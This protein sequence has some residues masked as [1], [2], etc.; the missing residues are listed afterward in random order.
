MVRWIRRLLFHQAVEEQLDAELRFHLDQQSEEYVARGMSPEEAH[1]RA[2][3]DMAGVEQ[4][5]QRCRERRWENRLEGVVRDI[6]FAMRRL[7]KEA[8]FSVMAILA[9]SLG[10]GSATL[11]FSLVYNLLFQPFP[12]RSF[13]RSTVV[14][15]HDMSETG[16][17]GR[18]LFSIPEFL[19]FRERNHA[20]EDVVGYNNAVNISYNDG[21]GTREIFGSHGV[22]SHAGSG[23]AYVTTNTF[24][25]YG[26]VPLSGRGIKQEDGNPGAQPVFVMNYRLWQEMFHGDPS[27]LG[28]SFLLNGEARTLVGIMPPRFQIY[29]AGVWLPIVLD[30]GSSQIPEGLNI[31]GSLKPG[32]S[33][34]AAAAD[35][36][37]IARGLAKVYPGKYPVRFTVITETLVESLLRRFKTTLYAL[38]VAVSML[39]LIACTNVASLL[40]VRA[41]TRQGEV[42]L[43][44]SLGAS[45]TRLTQQFLVEALVLASAGCILGCIL[46]YASLKWLVALIPAHRIP[47]GVVFHLNLPVLFFAVAISMVTTLVCGFVPALHVVGRTLQAPLTGSGRGSSGGG[48]G[49]R[50]TGLVIAQIAIS[51]VLLTAAGL[52]MRS[53]FA[54]DHVDL[55]FRPYSVLYAR[56][57]LPKGRYETAEPRRILLRKIVDRVRTLPGVIAAAETWSLPPDDRKWS[58][59]TIP[60][61]THSQEWDANTNLCSQD[62]FQTLDLR[63]LRGRLLSE[64]DVESARHVV[65]INQTL[66]HRFFGNDDPIGHSIKFNQFDNL[67][68]TPHDAYFEIIGIV[69][70]YRNAGLKRQPVPEAL[71]PYTI[72]PRGV[73]NILARTALKPN[74]LLKSVYQSVWAVDPE[75]GIGMSGSLGNLLDEYEY[76]EPL[77]EVAV[78]GAFAGMGLL[79]VIVGVYSVMAYTVALRTHE[80]GVRAALG[81]Q[82][83]V[84]VWMVLKRALGMIMAGI[85]IG[86]FGSLGVTHLLA[87][88]LWGVSVTDPWTFASVVVCVLVVGLAACSMPARRAAQVDP[89]ITLRYE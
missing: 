26:V 24:D 52:M 10:I 82:P 14:R 16:N 68:D 83:G 1:R 29:G 36:T 76:E 77:F 63:L 25:Y 12:Y 57:N 74:L 34:Q 84:I 87:S 62:Y 65:V 42:A 27:I 55:G 47:D 3:I 79:L 60:G 46:A 48:L 58:D 86:V 61:K 37:A 17:D 7:V 70:D 59:V 33:L 18:D 67:P 89:L 4:V 88:Q 45:R 39:L 78:L 2:Q 51:I 30:P 50:R 9:L 53:F 85:L 40:L 66:A 41:T 5:K 69:A 71:M 8:R 28:K 21:S 22:E 31:I 38:L 11:V 64:A 35:L 20:F 56:L 32:V 19:A 49:G 72:S 54:L 13:Q 81:A 23:G 44:A 6:R 15:I 73:P 75:V 80:I 43:R